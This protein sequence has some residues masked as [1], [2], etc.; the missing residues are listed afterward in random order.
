MYL[1]EMSHP[2]KLVHLVYLQKLYECACGAQHTRNGGG[3]DVGRV[4]G[5]SGKNS[6]QAGTKRHWALPLTKAP[7]AASGNMESKSLYASS[8]ELTDKPYKKANDLMKLD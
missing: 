7:S 2:T 4:V 1:G 5:Q 6:P 3:S 8:H